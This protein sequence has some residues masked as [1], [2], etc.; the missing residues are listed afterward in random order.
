M[1]LL[2]K[3]ISGLQ[4]SAQSRQLVKI[5]RFGRRCTRCSL[6][7]F[8]NP[9]GKAVTVFVLVFDF[10]ISLRTWH[11]F[12]H[13]AAIFKKSLIS[14]KYGKVVIIFLVSF[15]LSVPLHLPS[16]FWMLSLRRRRPTILK[17]KVTWLFNFTLKAQLILL[18][19]HSLANRAALLG[20]RPHLLRWYFTAGLLDRLSLAG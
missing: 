7:F 1:V 19:T 15:F 3:K 20:C 11:I 12:Y 9:S 14:T 8:V 2:L 10:C 16:L 4:I 6:R 5:L 13:S 17:R 18:L